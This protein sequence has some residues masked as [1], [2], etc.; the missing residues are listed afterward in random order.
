MGQRQVLERVVNRLLENRHIGV[1]CNTGFHKAAVR[2]YERPARR[3]RL[4]TGT[5]GQLLPYAGAQGT[6]SSYCEAAIHRVSKYK[7][8]LSRHA[9]ESR[10]FGGVC[11]A[12][13]V[14]AVCYWVPTGPGSIV[15]D[16]FESARRD[17]AN[18]GAN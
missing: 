16:G 6:A 10:L 1:S 11:R 7:R 8:E 4:G 13:H 3:V 2:D 9:I 12:R 15:Y 14:S 5:F 17:I 18:Y